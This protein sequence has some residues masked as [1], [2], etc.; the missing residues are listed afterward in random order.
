LAKAW[1]IQRADR[2]RFI[3]FFGADL[4]VVPGDQAQ[5]RLNGFHEFC[6]D[7]VLRTTPGAAR[8]GGGAA[9]PVVELPPDLVESETVALIYAGRR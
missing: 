2:Q 4:V 1:E 3:R 8:R 9:A 5:Q 7:E 6:R